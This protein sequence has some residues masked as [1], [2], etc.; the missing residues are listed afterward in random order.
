MIHSKTTAHR[1]TGHRLRVDLA[2]ALALTLLAAAPRLVALGSVP[3]GMHFDE[4]YNALDA[5]KVIAGDRPMFFTGNFGREPLFLYAHRPRLQ[6]LR[7]GSGGAAGPRRPGGDARRAPH[8]RHRPRR[9]AQARLA[10]VAGRPGAGDAAV[11]PALQPLWPAHRAAA[12]AGQRRRALPA[13]G[14]ALRAQALVRCRRG[15]ARPRPLWLHGSAA[16]GRRLPRLGPACPLAAGTERA[17]AAARRPGARRHR[18]A[19]RL[20][21]AGPTTSCATRR[22]SA[23]APVRWCSRAGRLP[24]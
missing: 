14:L 16:P 10:R 6:P 5:L 15:P 20:R 2:I 23:C 24:W 9:R 7:A 19:D 8:L 4:A 3:P 21:P 11:G 22:T 13:A 18:H 1:D 17:P 12:A